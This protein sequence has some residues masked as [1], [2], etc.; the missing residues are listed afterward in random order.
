MTW[1]LI[2]IDDGITD[3]A[4]ARAG[5]QTAIE[6][7]YYFDFPDTDD[8]IS[9]THGDRVFLSALG[10]SRAYDVIDLKVASAEFGDYLPE[11]TELALLDVLDTPEVPVG[12]INLSFGGPTY[13]FQYADE[14]AQLAALGI[15]SVVSAGNDGARSTIESPLFPAALPDVICVGSHDGAGRP[16]DFS[17]NGP[18]VDILADGE[19]VPR[20]GSDGTSFAAPRVAATVTHVQAIVDG[21]TG[22]VLNVAQVIDVLQQGGAG[23]RSRPDPADGHTRYFLHDHDGSLDYAWSRYGG[24][25]T[26]GPGV[27]RQPPGPDQRPRCRCPQ[28]SVAL[29]AHGQHRAAR[30]HL[31]QHRLHRILHRPGQRVRCRRAGW[32]SSLH[33][34][35]SSRGPQRHLQRPRLHRFLRR[36]DRRLR[37]RRGRGGFAFCCFR[38]ARGPLDDVRWPG[39]HRLLRRSDR[40]VRAE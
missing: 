34:S 36:P 35:G 5:K 9:D 14:I 17:R 11:Y 6:Y 2:I 33:H 4:Q 38:R 30:D 24:S 37:H 13:P 40:H 12:A 15:I 7:D 10:V 18:A 1:S 39:I 20:A 27:C 23:P 25:T 3:D 16:S 8:G 26:R 28:W 32:C 29:R 19:D 31:R 21:L 22:N